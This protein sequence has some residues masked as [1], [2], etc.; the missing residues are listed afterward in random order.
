MLGSIVYDLVILVNLANLVISVSGGYREYD[1]FYLIF[2]EFA[3]VL[4]GFSLL[5]MIFESLYLFMVKNQHPTN[6][7]CKTKEDTK[8]IQ[9]KMK[10]EHILRNHFP[11][12]LCLQRWL[13]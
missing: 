1:E 11:Q 8:Q 7:K 9:I 2:R 10:Q 4:H 12:K 13:S 5:T 3:K 6:M